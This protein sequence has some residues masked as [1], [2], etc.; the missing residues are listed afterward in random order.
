M[1]S[2]ASDWYIISNTDELDTPALV[3]YPDRVISNI[4]LLK[5]M[6][7]DISR[8]RPHAKTHKNSDA[9]K[10]MLQA[11]ITKFKCATI[12]EAEMLGMAG[13][14]DVLLAYQ[15][16]G[17]K[18]KRFVQLIK[19]YPQTAYSCL[20]DND[21][22]AHAVANEATASDA[23][24]SVYIDMNVG[25]NRTGI[26]PGA[27][28]LAL[29]KKCLQL[30][31]L[32]MAG[33]HAYDGHIHDS[34]YSVRQKRSDE[35]LSPVFKLMDDITTA[36]YARPQ[37]IAGGSPTFPIV[38][39]IKGIQV[40]PGTFVY[41]DKGYQAAYPEQPFLPSALLIARVVSL[42]EDG[43]ICIDLGHKSV[44]AEN[45]LA[46]R[47][48]FLNAPELKF[49]SHSE[50]HLVADAGKHHHYKVGD[51][52]YGLP[53]H[54]CPSVALYE[55]ALTIEDKLVTGEWRTIARDRKIT[56]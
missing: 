52:L 9:A 11:G 10:L 1:N 44:S 45:E 17:P 40:S 50:E 16:T 14:P 2:T 37:L 18:L 27:D 31:G 46:K 34:D 47:V 12:A 41:W 20:V 21:V 54:I 13:A 22:T 32:N 38:S 8:L 39:K 53:Y 28:A 29:Y 49:I 30:P 6:V 5:T 42:P 3:V 4:N 26:I 7:D 19:A 24:I 35:S 23:V 55:C 48:Y 51:V 33:L 56:I 36:G 25:M 43:K 15:P